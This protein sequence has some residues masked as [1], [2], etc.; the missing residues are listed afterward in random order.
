MVE[1][2]RF[3]V[4]GSRLVV[5][6]SRCSA[7]AAVENA[8][9]MPVTSALGGGSMAGA[10]R[11]SLVSSPHA[12][13]VV[14]LRTA[15]TEAVQLAARSLESPLH[16]PE[17]RCPKCLANRGE[18]ASC[19]QCGLVFAKFNPA[20]V[21]VPQ[22]LLDAWRD[23]L[24]DWGNQLRH[25]RLRTEASQQGALSQLG[26]LYRLRLAWFPDDPWAEAGRAEIVRMAEVAVS[27]GLIDAQPANRNE[28]AQGKKLFAVIGIVALLGAALSYLGYLLLKTS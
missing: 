6:C 16:V 20:T 13:N 7:E 26:R 24:G 5:T 17:G 15:A 14:T 23:L 22:W 19:P 11:V 10:A 8:S 27:A 28:S 2:E 1:L 25:E 18:H 4:E 12:S 9:A 21:E 3:R